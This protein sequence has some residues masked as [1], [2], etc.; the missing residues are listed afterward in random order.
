MTDTPS[1]RDGPLVVI[2]EDAALTAA[3]RAAL[4][5]LAPRPPDRHP[6]M[7]YLARLAPGFRRTMRAALETIAQLLTGGQATAASLAWGRSAINIPLPSGRWWPSAMRRRPPINC[8][9]RCA[10]C[11]TRP[12][13]WGI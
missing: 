7:V 1:H 4:V 6:A 12:G 9:P 13:G 5:T 3:D 10:G 2:H 8:W 11:C